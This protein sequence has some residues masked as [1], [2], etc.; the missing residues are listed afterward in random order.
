MKTRS[1]QIY[2]SRKCYM[3]KEFYA[4][5]QFNNLCSEC[6]C[7]KYPKKMKKIKDMEICKYHIDIY[8]E[9]KLIKENTIPETNGMYKYLIN[10]LKKH[11]GKKMIQ[12]HVAEMLFMICYTMKKAISSKQAGLIYHL[13]GTIGKN[14]TYNKDYQFQHFLAGF[15]YDYWN[16]NGKENGSIAECY[17]GQYKP[18]KEE[19]NNL[20]T[21]AALIPI[22]GREWKLI[23]NLTNRYYFWYKNIPDELK[24]SNM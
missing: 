1:G 12:K 8:E 21:P 4:N 14:K 23:S 11:S 17:Y 3:C 16:I 7:K 20:R 22:F 18:L 2:N 24:Q 15:I 5:K 6:C 10:N 9:I 13:T 19:I